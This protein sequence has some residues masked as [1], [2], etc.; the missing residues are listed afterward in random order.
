MGV[1][2]KN[3]S[4]M[5]RPNCEYLPA[6]LRGCA[7][8]RI[9]LPTVLIDPASSASLSASICQVDTDHAGSDTSAGADTQGL[10]PAGA[11]VSISG[12]TAHNWVTQTTASSGLEATDVMGRTEASV[13][14]APADRVSH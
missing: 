11:L 14:S 4:G 8:A 10:D 2:N 1:S 6:Q 5:S 12:N 9:G 13:V 3:T 7:A